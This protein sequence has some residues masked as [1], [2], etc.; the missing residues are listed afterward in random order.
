LRSI[1][2][3]LYRRE[4]S[5]L[6]P[7][8]AYEDVIVYEWDN[9]GT[10]ACR[11]SGIL[12]SKGVSHWPYDRKWCGHDW[13]YWRDILPNYLSTLGSR[14]DGRCSA[15]HAREMVHDLSASTRL[16]VGVA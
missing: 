11:L 16:T 10:K 9:T 1:Q 15:M 4:A 3:E 12:N 14:S 13:N 2:S 6:Q 8:R 7:E 5:S